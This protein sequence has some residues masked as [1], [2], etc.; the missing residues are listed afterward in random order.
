MAKY[1]AVSEAIGDKPK[2]VLSYIRGEKMYRRGNFHPVPNSVLLMMAVKY[3]DGRPAVCYDLI[4]GTLPQQVIDDLLD[5]SVI[6]YAWNAAFERATIGYYLGIYM[7]PEQWR[8][9][10]HRAQM[11]GLPNS[12]DDAAQALGVKN[13]KDK[14]GTRLIGVFSVPCKPTKKNGGRVRNMP[15][16]FPEDWA[17]FMRYCAQD[18]E[19]EFDI[20]DALAWYVIPEREQR[21]WNHDQRMGDRGVNV[22]LGMARSAL[23]IDD[24]FK[25]QTLLRAQRLTGLANP[26]AAPQMR[27]W[28]E[29]RLALIGRP[30][31]LT[32]VDKDALDLL[33]MKFDSYGDAEAVHAIQMKRE[34]SKTSIRKYDKLFQMVCRDGR[35]HHVIQNYGAGR[36]GRAAGRGVQVHNLPKGDDYEDYIDTMRR[37]VVED[38]GELLD[39]LYGPVSGCLSALIR[40]AF[41]S[42]PGKVLNVLDFSAIEARVTAWLAGQ[43][44]RMD[45]FRGHGMIYEASAAMMFDVDIDTIAKKV[46]G[47]KIKGPNYGLRGK[48]KIA[49]LALGFGGSVGALQ[50]ADKGKSGLSKLEM[51]RIVHGWR[52]VNGKIVELWA[53]FDAAAIKCVETGET[54]TSVFGIRFEYARGHMFIVLPSGRK[55]T[56]WKAHTQVREKEYEK[57]TEMEDGTIRIEK[58]KFTKNTVCYWGMQDADKNKSGA[59]I[60]SVQT[61]YGGKLTENIVQAIARDLLYIAVDKITLKGYDIVMHVHDEI[62]EEGYPHHMDE[63]KATMSEVPEWAPGLP[64]GVSAFT[65]EYYKK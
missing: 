61:T 39:F 48:G 47:E 17:A 42:A 32:S 8:C 25:A 1:I 30:T 16:H 22:S 28:L 65:S 29:Q 23:D 12:L 35:V 5:S 20:H 13:Q 54:V 37:L 63:L 43:D 57:I 49:E 51:Y 56:Y 64:M 2:Q 62:V 44:W 60:W 45:V 59:K 46:D 34:L 9:T 58:K 10:M 55:L 40:T 7:P 19:A 6:K 4:N 38:R 50:Q 21:Y 24:Q 27:T 11:C 52:K 53:A 15:E 41:I 26:A 33:E 3:D 14:E 36:T 31:T 18:V